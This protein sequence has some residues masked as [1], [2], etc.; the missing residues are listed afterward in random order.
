MSILSMECYQLFAYN[1]IIII[2]KIQ[3]RRLHLA[4]MN[5]SLLTHFCNRILEDRCS[6]ACQLEF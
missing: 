1:I 4:S 2:M 5:F 3:I 6:I